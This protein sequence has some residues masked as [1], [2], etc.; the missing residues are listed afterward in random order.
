M[1]FTC[2]E[3]TEAFSLDVRGVLHIGAHKFEE[4][5]SYIAS[6]WSPRV[7]IEANEALLDREAFA[8]NSEDRIIKAA[9]WS[10]DGVILDFNIMSN[11]ECSSLLNLGLTSEYYPE[12]QLIGV[13]KVLGRRVDAIF[14]DASIPNFVNVDVQGSELHVLQGFGERLWEIDFVY[15]EINKKDLYL[16][17]S[18]V[19]Q[20]DEFLGA[21]GFSRI[22]TRWVPLRHWGDALYVRPERIRIQKWKFFRLILNSA[23]HYVFG[24]CVESTQNLKLLLTTFRAR[25]ESCTSA[26]D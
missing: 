20:I 13:N 22:A 5:A 11:S 16:S 26:L 21:F 14:E 10:E 4:R 23:K 2:S 8:E 3:L 15:C 1:L 9:C 17:C 18:R 25:F 7:W 6:G 19:E 12:V 24:F